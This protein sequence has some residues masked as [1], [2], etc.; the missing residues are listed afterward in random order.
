MSRAVVVVGAG[1]A[2]LALVAATASRR[3][4]PRGSSRRV[5]LV[6]DSY[7]EGLGPILAKLAAAEGASFRF[8]GHVSTRGEQWAKGQAAAGH[9]APWLEDWGPTDILVSLGANDAGTSSDALRPFYTSLR[10]RF[11][12]MGARVTWLHPPRFS[13]AVSSAYGAIDSLGVDVFHTEDLNLPLRANHP[14]LAGY[15]AWAQAIWHDLTGELA[16]A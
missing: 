10:D 14:T 6:G 12:A 1:A 8:E 11:R 2:V 3:G 13:A 7:A 9:A 5:A 15:S 16:R 4:R